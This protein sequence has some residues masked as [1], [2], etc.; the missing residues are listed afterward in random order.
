MA[1]PASFDES[2]NV[3]DR[4]SDMTEDQCQS[5]STFHGIDTNNLPIVISCWKVTAEELA[6]INRTGRIW[7]G[8][9]GQTMPPAWISGHRPFE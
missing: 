7:L 6:E 8:I 5:L 4:P 2:N 9:V 1:F 3:L